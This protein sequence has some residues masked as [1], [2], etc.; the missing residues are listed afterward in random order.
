VLYGGT[1]FQDLVGDRSRIPHAL[2]DSTPKRESY[3]AHRVQ[4]RTGSVLADVL[5]AEFDVPSWHHQGVG[6]VGD[7]LTADA[8]ANDG[9]VEAVSDGDRPFV[10]GVQ[11]HP[12]AESGNALFAALVKAAKGE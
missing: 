10:V 7:G 3:V 5:G 9:L 12:E 11:W 2:P 4:A 1:L 6:R 8:W